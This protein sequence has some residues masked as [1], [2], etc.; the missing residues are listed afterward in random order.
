MECCNEYYLPFIVLS[1]VNEDRKEGDLIELKN[2]KGG[3]VIG[4]ESRAAFSQ[5]K[6]KYTD[7]LGE[8][9]WHDCK[10]TIGNKK[11]KL[12]TFN[13]ISGKIKSVHEC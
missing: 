1:Q 13:Q 11:D 4:E 9:L 6:T 5:N 7:A 12:I 10:R 8:V 3:R 2:T